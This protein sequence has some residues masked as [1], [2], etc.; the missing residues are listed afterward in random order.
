M[1]CIDTAANDTDQ[2]TQSFMPALGE[3]A[4]VTSSHN[5]YKSN[6]AYDQEEP[7]HKENATE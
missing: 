4:G 2:R 5:V 7:N 1:S 3:R 6:R